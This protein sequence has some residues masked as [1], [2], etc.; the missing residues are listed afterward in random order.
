MAQACKGLGPLMVNVVPPLSLVK[1]ISADAGSAI[2]DYFN[3]FAEVSVS[4]DAEERI[5]PASSNET[6]DKENIS[7]PNTMEQKARTKT[8]K[9]EPTHISTG[10]DEPPR[11]CKLGRDVKVSGI[12]DTSVTINLSV[13][14]PIPSLASGNTAEANL[15][16][17]GWL[18]LTPTLQGYT[19]KGGPCGEKGYCIDE[20]MD[21]GVTVTIELG[22]KFEAGGAAG[23]ELLGKIGVKSGVEF[24]FKS[25]KSASIPLDCKSKC[26]EII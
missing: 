25:E 18:K 20:S 19:I 7:M 22:F 4:V 11:C 24:K 9:E 3:Q 26:P 5:C 2:A 1:A 21:V 23:S 13:T 17:S 14:V 10:G 16:I 6:S 8:T 15:T 12:V